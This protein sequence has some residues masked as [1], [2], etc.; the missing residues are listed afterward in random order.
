M[1]LVDL[2]DAETGQVVTVDSSSAVFQKYYQNFISQQ[3][4]HREGELRKAGV[5]RIEVVSGANFVD[6]L[7]AY[8][9]KK[10]GRR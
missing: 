1:G 3:R 4:T 9:R 10:G 8:F 6:P 7:V 5:D 2:H